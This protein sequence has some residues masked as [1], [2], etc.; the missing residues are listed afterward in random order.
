M[1]AVKSWWRKS[2]PRILSGPISFLV[3]L[4]G[5]TLRARTPGLEEASSLPTG[6]IA[7]GWHGRTL[8]PAVLLQNRGWSTIIS[9]S[10]DGEMQN[11]VF[12]SLGFG[13]IRGSTGRGGVKV[14]VESIRLLKE[15]GR[16]AFTPD[17]PRG[18]SGVVQPGVLMM[19]KKSGAAIIPVASS[20]RW[21]WLAPTWDRYLVPL[22][23]S[24]AIM[25]FGDP[26][27]ISPHA[28]DEEIQR[29]AV[30]LEQILHDME[31]EVEDELGVPMSK[32]HTHSNGQGKGGLG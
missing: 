30:M 7:C 1:G 15:G 20:A 16:L 24:R 6:L 21:R 25:R 5:R 3:R 11:R 32:R 2:R 26:I 12:R 9:L 22:P 10:N 14:L 18:P 28:G 13:A 8:L 23:F 29:V 27:Y 31:Q 17:G 4:V 19:A